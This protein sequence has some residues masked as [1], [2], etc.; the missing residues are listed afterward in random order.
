[1]QYPIFRGLFVRIPIGRRMLLYW[2]KFR[3]NRKENKTT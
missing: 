1:M 2:P 3:F